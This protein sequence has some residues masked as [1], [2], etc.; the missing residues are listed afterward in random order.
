MKG[1]ITHRGLLSCDDWGGFEVRNQ[2]LLLVYLLC[3]IR[4]SCARAIS[5]AF[6]GAF[7]G[8]GSEVE[9]LAIDL[10]PIRDVGAA[11]GA[12]AYYTKMPVPTGS[13]GKVNLNMM[14]VIRGENNSYYFIL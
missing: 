7:A 5:I 2:E 1:K 4:G 12:L 11:E 9:Q 10:G 8:V 13:F 14:H 6:P 3:G